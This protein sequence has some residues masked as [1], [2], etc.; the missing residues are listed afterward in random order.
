MQE[1]TKDI[2]DSAGRQIQSY[3][4]ET[5]TNSQ[6]YMSSSLEIAQLKQDLQKVHGKL[7]NV[8]DYTS[9]KTTTHDTVSIALHDTVADTG[10]IHIP[11]VATPDS[12]LTLLGYTTLH[13]I[14]GSLVT[15]SVEVIY[16]IHNR[17]SITHYTQHKFLRPQTIN[18]LITS[19]NNH[20]DIGKVQT[21]TVVT[22]RKFLQKWYVHVAAGVVATLVVQHY[23]K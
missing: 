2:R 13:H 19:D 11:F 6:L 22:N 23:V 16:S 21:Y 3:K 1:K 4:L 14:P 12:F 5:I 8:K 9:V 7:H 18:L 15:D 20:T 10:I 17:L